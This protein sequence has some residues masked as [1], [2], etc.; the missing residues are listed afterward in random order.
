MKIFSTTAFLVALLLASAVAGRSQTTSA[1]AKHFNKDGVLFDYLP[2]W[3]LQ[4]DS[5]SDAQQ[6]TLARADSDVQIRVFAHRG[7]I[8]EEKMPQARK[9]FIDT[10][11]DATMKQFIQMGA[12]PEQSPDSTDIGTSK[13]EGVNI[14]A[15]LGGETGAAKIYW[16]LIGQRVVVLTYFGPD[17]DLKKQTAAWDLL[18]GTLQIEEKKPSPKPSPSPK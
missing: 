4:D 18:R 17:K 7:R 9:A 16:A 1:D 15:S 12:K 13:A 2:S 11:I 3:T 6:L 10:Y 5:N 8:T 14:K